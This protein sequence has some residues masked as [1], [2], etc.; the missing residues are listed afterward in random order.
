[1]SKQPK[2]T[3]KGLRKQGFKVSVRHF[4]KA[5][6][7]S[8][9]SGLTISRLR[10]N[11]IHCPPLEAKGG[12]TEV[13]LIDPNGLTWYGA[14]TCHP[15][16]ECYVKKEGTHKALHKA[17]G[18]YMRHVMGRK[19]IEIP[20]NDP[21][22]IEE[23]QRAMDAYYDEYCKYI[24]DFAEKKNIS[25]ACASDVIYLRSRSRRLAP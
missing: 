14:I 7:G 11:G 13:F 21:K 15:T 3:V 1:M 23:F 20:H 8:T 10:T 24:D 9:V 4:R 25:T 19:K 5:K 2:Q 18:K 17:Y 12:Y 22:K 16:K 6:D